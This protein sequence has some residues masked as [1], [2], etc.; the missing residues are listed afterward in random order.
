MQ[1]KKPKTDLK[2]EK[3]LPNYKNHNIKN[4]TQ[5]KMTF[6]FYE[7]L[8]KDS[9]KIDIESNDNKKFEYTYIYQIA[10]FRSMKEAEW[11]VKKM[12]EYKLIP[13]FEQ[14][15][16]WIRMYIGPYKSKRSIAPDIIKLQK[17]GL[18][19]GFIK[20]ISKTKINKNYDKN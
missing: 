8:K 6:T 3:D 16:D 18:N 12:K 2:I 10:S 9:V 4:K 7:R 14:V 17:I 19:G 11:Y 1:N 20:E 13:K 15:G 5:D